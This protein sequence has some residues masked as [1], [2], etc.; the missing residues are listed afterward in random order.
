[1]AEESTSQTVTIRVDPKSIWRIIGALLITSL[2]LWTI[3][4]AQHL[5]V[6]VAMSFLF[7]LALQP[8][9]LRQTSKYGWRRGGR[10]GECHEERRQL[11]PDTGLLS[12]T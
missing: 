7:S 5:L 4:E 9:V 6:L 12:G 3:G 10:A 1:M 2:A 8:A 11:I